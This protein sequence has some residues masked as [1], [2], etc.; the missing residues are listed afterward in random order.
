MKRKPDNRIIDKIRNNPVLAN[1]LLDETSFSD[2]YI[3]I[4][5]KKFKAGMIIAQEGGKSSSMYILLS[6]K[7]EIIKKTP[8]GDLFNAGFVFDRDD[9]FFGESSL[10]KDDFYDFSVR[11]E[12]NTVWLELPGDKF[13][14]FAE[15]NPSACFPVVMA[16]AEM[17]SE[18]IRKV[19]KDMMTLYEAL[20]HEIKS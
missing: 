8:S 2:I 17:I 14:T 12:T 5:E 9:F 18:K 4:A 6:G 3:R 16:V 11:S 10:I 19:R 1:L 7:A 15:D 20:V 13:R